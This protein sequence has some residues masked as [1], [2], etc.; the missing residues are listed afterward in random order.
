M[1]SVTLRNGVCWTCRERSHVDFSLP[2]A[3]SECLTERVIWPPHCSLKQSSECVNDGFKKSRGLLPAVGRERVL[4]RA[5]NLAPSL[6]SQAELRMERSHVDL[7]L[8]WAESEC[9]TERVIWPPHCCL[10]QSSE[11]VN[12]G[13]NK[14][15]GPLPAVGRERVLDR[16]SN[17]APSLLSQA[18]L[19]KKHPPSLVTETQ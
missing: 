8:P 4:D 16:A 19:R 9:L 7:S 1:A 3:E 6:L 18:E 14:S 2:W 5:S 10:K 17:L 11:C 15:R 12:D 13:F